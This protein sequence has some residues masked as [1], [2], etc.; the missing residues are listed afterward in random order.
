MLARF[1]VETTYYDPLIGAGIAA[2]IRP[3]TRLVFIESAGL[4]HLRDAGH[5]G[6]RRGRARPRLPGR[7]G[8]HLGLAPV[9]Q[10][11]RSIGVDI[12]IQAATKYI[13]GH[14]DLMMGVVTCTEAALRAAAARHAGARRTA[15]RPTTAIRRCAACAR[16]RSGSSATS[17]ARLIVAEWLAGRPG[18]RARALPCP[19]RRSRP[20]ALAAGFPRRLR[21]VRH[22]PRAL[23]EGGGRGHARQ[24]GAVRHGLQLG[25]L[26]EPDHP[27]PTPGATAPRRPGTR[28]A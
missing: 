22:D 4:A 1:G 8:Q 14:S 20:R 25:R 17:A 26:R 2:L 18:G 19:A 5:A 23:L 9:L 13:G 3:E 12:S 24:P 16:W 11:V 10:A 15:S 21:A 28:T 7:D 6:D 27:D